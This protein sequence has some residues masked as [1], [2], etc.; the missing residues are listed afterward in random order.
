MQKNY[1][2]EQAGFNSDGTIRTRGYIPSIKVF[3]LDGFDIVR[4]F[5]D[6]E[7]NK[8]D[9]G[10]DITSK[11]IQGKAY[12]VNFKF[13][14]R[15]YIDD[16][17]V[18]GPFFDAGRLFVDTIRP[19]DLRTSTGLTLKFLTPVGTLDF[20]YGVKL[21]RQDLGNGNRESFGRFHL[22]IGYF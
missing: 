15:Y 8:V 6:N 12:F 18:I 1:A 5:A 11:R 3:R 4:G 19:A 7:I 9:E 21:N 20:D 13:E 14:P 2:N 16:T 10:E 17:L 22:S